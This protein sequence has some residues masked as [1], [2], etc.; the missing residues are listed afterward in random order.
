MP[1]VAFKELMA[2]A[3]R[4]EFAVGYFESW[5]LESLRAVADAAESVR[6]PV[7]LGFSGIYL[8]HPRR[9]V[10]EPLSVY[11]A[12][13]KETCCQLKTPACLV[14]NESPHFERVLEAI[15]LGFG[16]VMFSDPSLGFREQ[17]E[18]VRQIGAQ[19]HRAGLAVEGE[20]T[21]LPGLDGHLAAPPERIDL[22]DP[23][24]ARSFVESTGIDALAVNVGQAHLHGRTE[25]RLDLNRLACLKQAVPVPLVLHG[26]SSICR[27]DL[28]A[29]IRL[30]VRKINVGSVLKRSYAEALRSS[31][32]RL[33]GA[34]NPYE[35]IGS[36]LDAD[37][38]TQGRIA[39][40]EVVE[41]L[42]RLFGSAG[43]G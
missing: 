18:R 17:S 38:L 27:D 35:A 13:G 8:H 24:Q 39:L 10:R 22:S 34:Y 1:V 3:E 30:G 7:L 33:D 15:E 32:H 42:M 29:A 11:A 31:I 40:Q 21:S 14:F 28:K 19:A 20:M 12:L 23:Q 4:G 2:E 6:A 43:K 16:L 25:L 41:D 5:N 9:R 26:S 36:G 37:V